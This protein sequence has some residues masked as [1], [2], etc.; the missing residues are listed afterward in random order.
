MNKKYLTL[1]IATLLI[2]TGLDIS[3]AKAAGPYDLHGWAWSSNIGWVSLNSSDSGAGGST[4]KVQM[5]D[6]GSLSGF[7]W[8]SNIGWIS[9]NAG[10]LSGCSSNTGASINLSTGLISGWIRALSGLGRT[11]GWDGV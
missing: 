1:I 5:Q 2:V 8:S 3:R 10:D 9:F 11:D 6:S 7:A 4:Y